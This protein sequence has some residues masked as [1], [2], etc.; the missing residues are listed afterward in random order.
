VVSTNH[1]TAGWCAV[2]AGAL[3]LEIASLRSDDHNATLSAHARL[4]FNRNHFSRAL[5]VGACAWWAVHVI[6][7][8]R[9]K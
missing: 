6:Q 9:K 2:A 3:A 7:P 4:L 5:L 8:G 1:Y